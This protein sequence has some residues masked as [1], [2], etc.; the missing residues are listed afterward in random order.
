MHLMK[1]VIF[2]LGFEERDMEKIK[3]IE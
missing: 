3:I 1:P 2:M